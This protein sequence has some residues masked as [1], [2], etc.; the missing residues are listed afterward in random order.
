M[1]MCAAPVSPGSGGADRP[2]VGTA[3][4]PSLSAMI[5]GLLP[6]DVLHQLCCWQVVFTNQ[7]RENSSTAHSWL[8]N[9]HHK[10]KSVHSMQ[11][12]QI[13]MLK[14]YQILMLTYTF[15]WTVSSVL[16]SSDSKIGT[17]V[18]H[19]QENTACLHDW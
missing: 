1:C 11:P 16:R 15:R 6:H 3:A 19:L 14:Y 4:P 5:V 10:N 18:N 8:I 2:D 12:I 9:K 7:P 13:L 17:N